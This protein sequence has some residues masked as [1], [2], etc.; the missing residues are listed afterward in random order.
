MSK[1]V[2][3]ALRDRIMRTSA[4]EYPLT[5]LEISHSGLATPVRV[6]RDNLDITS[7]GNTYLAAAFRFVMPDDQEDQA[8]RASIAIDNVGKELMQ[9][10]EASGGGQGARVK[11]MQVLRSAP[12]TVDLQIEMDIISV[13]ATP[14]EVTAELG[15]DNIFF[16]PLTRAQYRPDTHPGMF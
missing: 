10:L 8:P 11:I 5:L 7:N 15:F 2:S 14:K 4:P 1:T 12:N 6:V 13:T 16:K 3:T 9:W